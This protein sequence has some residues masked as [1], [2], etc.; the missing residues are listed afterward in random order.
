MKY[1]DFELEADLS[2][3]ELEKRLAEKL[4]AIGDGGIARIA[5]GRDRSGKYRIFVRAWALKPEIA[6]AF[7]DIFGAQP[8][9]GDMP[10]LH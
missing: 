8:I 9:V 4:D 7:A 1:V 3:S 6:D 10:T 2:V 5:R